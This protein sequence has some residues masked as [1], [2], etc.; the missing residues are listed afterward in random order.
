MNP[1]FPR[2]ALVEEPRLMYRMNG[3]MPKQE[4]AN[5]NR[6][7]PLLVFRRLPTSAWADALLIAALP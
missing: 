7:R 5:T 3:A 4:S 6:S 2:L 1:I